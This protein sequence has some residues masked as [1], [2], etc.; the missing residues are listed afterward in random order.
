VEN[1]KKEAIEEGVY[2]V[3][4]VMLDC[5]LENREAALKKI[6]YKECISKLEPYSDIQ[7]ENMNSIDKIQ[8]MKYYLATIHREENTDSIEKLSNIIEGFE[9]LDLPVLFLVH[10]RT[11]NLIRRYQGQCIYKNILFVKPVSYYQ[12][13]VLMSHARKIITDT[14][15]VQKE[16]YFLKIPCVTLAEQTE[17][18]ET[19]DGG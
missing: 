13:I 11:I 18:I 17:W 6:P 8:E 12:M 5:I 3:G 1:L 10:P 15:G 9:A 14:G 19:L 4:D 2:H 16:A 7:F